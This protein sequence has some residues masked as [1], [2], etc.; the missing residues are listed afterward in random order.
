M[1]LTGTPVLNRPEELV[2]QLRA[3]GRLGDFGSGARLSRRFRD[4]GSDDLGAFVQRGA[5]TV[6]EVARRRRIRI[7]RRGGRHVR[8]G[9]VAGRV[10][11]EAALDELE[12]D[13]DDPAEILAL[14]RLHRR[15][16]HHAEAAE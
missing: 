8:G 1:A 15:D 6:Q 5:D 12:G 14:G 3:I 10:D 7:I 4:A 2:S 13:L 16:Q 9:G 11:R